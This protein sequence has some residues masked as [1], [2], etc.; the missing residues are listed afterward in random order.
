MKEYLFQGGHG[1]TVA[2]YTES[3]LGFYTFLNLN[4]CE[5]YYYIF[6]NLIYV[7]SVQEVVT[8]LC[9]NLLYKMGHYLLDI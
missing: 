8:H 4:I 3:I 2:R 7:R 5:Y 1:D 6:F 9:S